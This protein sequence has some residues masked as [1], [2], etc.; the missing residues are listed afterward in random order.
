MTMKNDPADAGTENTGDN[1]ASAEAAATNTTATTPPEQ[2]TATGEGQGQGEG[3]ANESTKGDKPEGEEE[4]VEGA[5][6][7]Y[8]PFELPEG[9]K[10]DE[11]LSSPELM[12]KAMAYAKEKNWTQAKAQEHI[13]LFINFMPEF[14]QAHSQLLRGTWAEESERQFGKDFA[15]I[16]TGA[17]SALVDLERARPGITDRL[18]ETNLGNHPDVLW[19]FNRIGQLLKDPAIKGMGAQP[20]ESTQ[21][22]KS[23]EEILYPNG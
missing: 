6:E 13:D 3:E 14:L 23:R 9:A 18:D 21:A 11:Y 16:S 22:P 1:P 8:E 17:Q 12:D 4:V 19:V 5:P 7:K 10:S 2:S 15:G 20:A